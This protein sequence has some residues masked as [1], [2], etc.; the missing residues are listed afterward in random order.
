MALQAQNISGAVE[1][2]APDQ[3]LTFSYIARTDMNNVNLSVQ[4]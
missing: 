2:L 4:T 3:N 1:K